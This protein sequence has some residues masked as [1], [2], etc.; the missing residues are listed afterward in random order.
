MKR[1]LLAYVWC[2]VGREVRRSLNHKS[3][4]DLSREWQVLQANLRMQMIPEMHTH[5]FRGLKKLSGSG[6]REELENI[7]YDSSTETSPDYSG[8][9]MK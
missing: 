2:V 9:M 4:L 3:L 7:P 8:C 6:R 1:M 5:I